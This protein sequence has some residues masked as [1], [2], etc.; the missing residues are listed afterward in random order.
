M[1]KRQCYHC[2][3]WLNPGEEHDCWSTTE[4][5]LTAGLS[6]DLKDAYERI[7]ETALAYGEQRVYAS[8]NSIMFSRKACYF[9]VRPQK[10]HLE[11]CIFLGRSVEAPQIRK[12]MPTSKS[13]FANILRIVHRDEVEAP[14]TDWLAEAYA[15]SPPEAPLAGKRSR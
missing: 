6:E 4:A 9:F 13:K 7:R 11:V 10:K 12:S 2:K 1:A 5:A 14:F 3:E 15:F 8:H